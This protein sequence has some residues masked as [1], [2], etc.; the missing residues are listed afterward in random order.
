MNLVVVPI[1][2][3]VMILMVVV[4]DVMIPAV[5]VVNHWW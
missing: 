2:V 4:E 1:I 3:D 5:E